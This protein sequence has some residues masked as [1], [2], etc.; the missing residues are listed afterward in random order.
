MNAAPAGVTGE[1]AHDA[2]LVI[3][4]QARD[5]DDARLL[6]EACGL[7]PYRHAKPKLKAEHSSVVKYPRPGQ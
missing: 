2:I 3:M 7:I 6:L 1:Q 4:G 5:A